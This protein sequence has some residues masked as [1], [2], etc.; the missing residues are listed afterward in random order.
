LDKIKSNSSD[1]F[2]QNLTLVGGR[3][4]LAGSVAIKAGWK[5]KSEVTAKLQGSGSL[6]Y[7]RHTFTSISLTKYILYFT[8]LLKGKEIE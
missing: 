8:Y 2:N 1:P 5:D 4:D 3:R 7:G 6:Q